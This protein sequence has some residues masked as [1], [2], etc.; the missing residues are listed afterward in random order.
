MTGSAATA[1]TDTDV[2]AV[3]VTGRVVST[4]PGAEGSIR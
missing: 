1:A 2:I 4:A 3:E